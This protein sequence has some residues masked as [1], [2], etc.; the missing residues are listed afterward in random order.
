LPHDPIRWPRL[1]AMRATGPRSGHGML[2]EQGYNTS[3]REQ[4][5]KSSS[6]FKD[7]TVQQYNTYDSPPPG[8]SSPT[9]LRTKLVLPVYGRG[10]LLRRGATRRG[11]QDG[12]ATCQNIRVQTASLRANRCIQISGFRF[13]T[14]ARESRARGG[15]R[16]GCGGGSQ[17]AKNQEIPGLF[18]CGG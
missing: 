4:L 11:R 3:V 9:D 6:Y 10:G 14:S 16:G 13:L 5:S 15:C 12:G 7:I 1:S 8:A 17:P 2:A 18:R